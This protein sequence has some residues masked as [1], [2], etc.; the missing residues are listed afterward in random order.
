MF[1]EQLP[2]SVCSSLDKINRQFI[3][4]GE[5]GKSSF[6]P[7]VWDQMVVPR[8]QGGADIRPTRLANQ[9]ML[10]KGAWKLA[11][12]DQALWVRIMKGKYGQSREGLDILKNTKGSSFAWRSFSHSTDLLRKGCA[13]N[14]KNGKKAKFWTDVW[15]MQVPLN[16]VATQT[17]P[18]EFLQRR[19]AH[20]W[21]E[22]HG[23]KIDELADYLG[24]ETLETIQA[25]HF[26][27]MT[28]EEDKL[29]WNLTTNGSFTTRIAYQALSPPLVPSKSA[30]FWKSIWKLHVPERVRVFIWMAVENKL[31]TKNIRKFRH[32]TTDDSC[33]YCENQRRI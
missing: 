32:L 9:A 21:H 31:T 10:A 27:P 5:E 6:H 29:R 33:P 4:G 26:D 22:D 25:F 17:I 12:N 20:Y 24:A 16:S 23:W 11:T 1:T 8:S 19:V 3:W 7:I 28:R 15:L 18:E 13:Y 30:T 14:I 2:A